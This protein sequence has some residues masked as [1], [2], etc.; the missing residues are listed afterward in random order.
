MTER[1]THLV[2]Q[3]GDADTFRH[4]FRRILVDGDQGK[5]PVEDNKLVCLY[6]FVVE[7]HH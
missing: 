7:W 5:M 2:G 3:V 6:L 4:C 1:E